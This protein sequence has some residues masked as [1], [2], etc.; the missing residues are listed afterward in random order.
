[1]A[2]PAIHGE[3]KRIYQLMLTP[4]ARQLLGQRARDLNVS[5][6]ELVEQIARGMIPAQSDQDPVHMGKLSPT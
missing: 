2:R 5:A 3:A 6:S 1:M 4:T